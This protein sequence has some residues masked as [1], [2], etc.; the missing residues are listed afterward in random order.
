MK[1]ILFLYDKLMLASEQQLVGLNSKFLGYAVVHGKMK[2]FPEREYGQL[3]RK[4]KKKFITPMS[5]TRN[6]FG[7]L[8]EVDEYELY[9]LKLHSYYYSM[10]PFI[11]EVTEDDMF[12]T[13]DVNAYPIRFKSLTALE[14]GKY[15]I[16]SPIIA[17][18]FVG[19]LQNKM[20]QHTIS[21]PYY[22]LQGIDH[23]NFIESVKETQLKQGE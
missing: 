17:L 21:K 23:K 7:A 4:K 6:I 2:W 1:V 8:Y 12:V 19:N 18:A 16:G 15:E 14:E 11:G 20:I 5:T 10:K 3:R 22:N 13:A 9:E